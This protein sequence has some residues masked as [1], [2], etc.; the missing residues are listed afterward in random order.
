MKDAATDRVR[1]LWAPEMA[2][3]DRR[4]FDAMTD[5]GLPRSCQK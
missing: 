1:H 5:V 2:A 3:A 4:I